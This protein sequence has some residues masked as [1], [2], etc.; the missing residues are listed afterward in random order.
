VG[1]SRK[2]IIL[3]V[4]LLFVFCV[5]INTENTFAKSSFCKENRLG[6][7]FYCDDEV[8]KVQQKTQQK[9]NK[10]QQVQQNKT[11]TERLEEYKKEL[12]EKKAKAVLEPTE[13]NIKDY[14]RFQMMTVDNAGLFSDVWR[15]IIWKNP[16]LDYTQQRPVSA[17]GKEVWSSNRNI[18]VTNTLK[19][20]N[21]RYGVFFIYSSTCPY[22]QKYAQILYDLKQQHNIE[23]KGVSI[24]GAFLPLWEKNSFANRGQL[25]QLGINYNTVPV[26]VLYDNFQQII[27]PVGYGLMTQD[28]VMERIYILTQK[29][30]GEDF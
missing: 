4:V 30:V 13:D 23:I 22:C 16:E 19:N 12:E 26:T 27:I 5:T 29:K 14:M 21:S 1:C 10:P 28:E 17:V 25:E 20:I 11:Y 8:E 18:Q 7:K 24:D 9:D 2:N 15:R 3:F 6:W